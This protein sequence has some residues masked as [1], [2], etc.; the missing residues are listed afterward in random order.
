DV[1]PAGVR[2]PRSG[3]VRRRRVH[4]GVLQPTQTTL[5]HRVPHPCPSLER[6]PRR[7]RPIPG[8]LTVQK[9][10]R[11]CPHSLTQPTARPPR[12]RL[13]SLLPQW[14]TYLYVS[15]SVSNSNC[16]CQSQI[17]EGAPSRT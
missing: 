10:P 2:H 12:L 4:R 13:I 14:T 3:T 15:R 11:N 7:P 17:G 5:K 1:P 8:G 16:A 6:A 9:S